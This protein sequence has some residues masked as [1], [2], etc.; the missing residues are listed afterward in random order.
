MKLL[1]HLKDVEEDFVGTFP[2]E[3]QLLW[4]EYKESDRATRAMMQSMVSRIQRA[5]SGKIQNELTT[6]PEGEA[7]QKARMRWDIGG[8]PQSLELR[9]Q[10]AKP[11][12]EQLE[13]IFGPMGAQPSAP[14]AVAPTAP[15]PAM[16]PQ[17]EPQ[18]DIEA[19]SEQNL[20]PAGR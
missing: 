17:G 20:I 13:E 6:H 3:A 9:E 15:P 7:M 18:F 11:L 5:V 14:P 2:E 8:L 12:V 19:W 16:T 1:R 4:K 10:I